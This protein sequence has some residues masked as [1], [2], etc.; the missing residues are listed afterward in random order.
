MANP[1]FK[2]VK[3]PSDQVASLEE[4]DR[5]EEPLLE[6][7]TQPLERGLPFEQGRPPLGQGE[8]SLER[9]GPPHEREGLP[10]EQKL[11]LSNRDKR[12][13]NKVWASL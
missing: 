9:E 12:F 7:E 10:H 11:A 8:P 1:A 5:Q 2:E 3:L 13:S 6:I 4:E